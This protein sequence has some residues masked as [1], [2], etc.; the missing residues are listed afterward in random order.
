MRGRFGV[1]ALPFL[2]DDR[3]G[4]AGTGPAVVVDAIAILELEYGETLFLEH[5]AR[6]MNFYESPDERST[7]IFSSALC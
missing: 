1:G 3:N 2:G 4:E 5:L 7:P 6:L